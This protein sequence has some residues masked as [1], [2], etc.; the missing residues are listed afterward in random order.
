MLWGG[1]AYMKRG[2]A[3]WGFTEGSTLLGESPHGKPS[4]EL[5]ESLSKFAEEWRSN[6]EVTMSL[7]SQF[8]SKVPACKRF[9][10]T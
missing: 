10:T 3:E 1:L 6:A 5:G 8:Q 2:N 4:T 7:R 9:A